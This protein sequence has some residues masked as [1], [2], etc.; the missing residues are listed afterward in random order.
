MLLKGQK[1]IVTGGTKGIGRAIALTFAKEGAHVV[2]V[3]TDATKGKEVVDE[4]HACGATGSFLQLDVSNY[5]QAGE[6]IKATVE[7]MGRIDVL[8]NNAGITRDGLLLRMSEQDWDQVID[9]NLK[10]CYTLCQAVLRP[11]MKQRSGSIVN[12]SSVVGLTGNPGQVNYAASKAG[13][14]GLSKAL[15]REVA[16]RNIRV[17]C[18]AP[19]FVETAM[20]K[21]IMEGHKDKLLASIPM[22]RV[23]QPEEIAQAV[24]F[25]SSSM[26]SYV[27]GQVLAVDGGMVMH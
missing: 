9:V 11:M 3:G 16:S 27:T 19:G 12:I 13:M 24:L 6:R 7:E 15:A 2:I 20:T 17:N 18:I 8:V 5:E 14:I 26:S 4:I 21:E 10:S 23:G 1:T 22:G 25:L